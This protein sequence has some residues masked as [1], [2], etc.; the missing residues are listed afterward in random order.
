MKKD[1]Y[2]K[3]Y[4]K[5]PDSKKIT[6]LKN[7][8]KGACYIFGDG[9]SLKYYDLSSFSD[10]PSISLGYL[11]L[12]NDSKFLNLKYILSCDSFCCVPG[13]SFY[14]YWLRIKTFIKSKKY[15]KALSCISPSKLFSIFFTSHSKIMFTDNEV[16][17]NSNFITH[18]TNH[19]FT[20]FLNN[21]FYFNYH[22]K[23]NENIDKDLGENLHK[24]Y[25]SSLNF[26]IYFSAF[27]GFKKIYLVGCDYEDIEPMLEHWWEKDKPKPWFDKKA[28]NYIEYMRKFIDIKIITLNKSNG[29]NFIS[30][31]DYSGKD[32]E[33]KENIQIIST[34]R[35]ELL[36]SRGIYKI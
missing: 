32:L 21:S 20:K 29:N 4:E 18:C 31:R 35:L 6:I 28:T 22:L 23:I 16:L 19:Y 8:E 9:K 7:I 27:L 1:F 5:V 26:S 12:H 25:E 10:L 17:L 13:N 33:Y 11:S 3:I 30:Y 34:K 24:V 15:S 2:K 36:K 14:R